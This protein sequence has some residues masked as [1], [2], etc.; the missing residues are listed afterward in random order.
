MIKILIGSFIIIIGF[1]MLF[2]N[3]SKI[4]NAN[5]KHYLIYKRRVAQTR[6]LCFFLI[7][8]GFF[9]ILSCFIEPASKPSGKVK[10]S[11]TV[12]IIGCVPYG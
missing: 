4:K 6:I 8:L 12:E 7:L 3:E 10:Q 11:P 2:R 1:I 9:L 5:P